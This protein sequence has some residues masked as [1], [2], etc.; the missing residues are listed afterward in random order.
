MQM[1]GEYITHVRH[2]FLKQPWGLFYKGCKVRTRASVAVPGCVCVSLL[3]VHYPFSHWINGAI[4]Q[5]QTCVSQ[6]TA[7]HSPT[8]GP[9]TGAPISTATVRMITG[10]RPG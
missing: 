6:R 4:D 10:A 8:A 9:D 3:A 5:R 2:S 7:D 1:E